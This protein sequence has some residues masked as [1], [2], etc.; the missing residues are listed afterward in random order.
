MSDTPDVE[1][2]SAWTPEQA[3]DLLKDCPAAW[4]VTAGWA[5]DV[6]HGRQN[7]EHSDLEIAI[8]RAEFDLLKPFLSGY[9]IY[10]AGAG[11]VNPL[12]P[13]LEVARRQM[14]V[15]E[16]D[17]W[18]MDIFLEAGD[19]QTWRNHR[20]AGV[21]KPFAEV[22]RF[23]A[24][25]IPYQSPETV[26]FMKAK[27]SRPK[28]EADFSLTLPTLDTGQLSWLIGSLERAH[29]GHPWIAA[30]QVALSGR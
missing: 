11:Q 19:R 15:R 3:Y 5:L 17:H 21:T 30:C 25:G 1:A 12:T 8:P 23:S 26:L 24:D 20:D 13:E 9:R 6:H 27:H 10:A 18:R 7:R 22:L 16:G 29:P 4:A 2:W 14:W 28:D